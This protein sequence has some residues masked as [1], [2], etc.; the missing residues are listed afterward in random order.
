MILLVFQRIGYYTFDRGW[1]NRIQ[2]T[3]AIIVVLSVEFVVFEMK[4]MLIRQIARIGTEAL[5]G[6]MACDTWFCHRSVVSDSC[7]GWSRYEF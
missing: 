4:P 5:C 3:T 2:E 7:H 6:E 1:L